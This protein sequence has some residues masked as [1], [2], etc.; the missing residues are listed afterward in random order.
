V[1][2]FNQDEQRLIRTAIEN[3]E[4]HS[5]GQLRVCIEKNCSGDAISRAAKYFYQLNMQKTRLRNGVLIYVATV[6]RKFAII[7]D[8][9]ITQLVSASFWDETKEAMLKH[10]KYGNIVDG[11]ITGIQIAG[12]YMQKYFPNESL[13]E[14]PDGR[15]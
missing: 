13:I 11:I 6:D 7:G 15:N 12:E 5:S 9:G 3:V 2:V 4:L 8:T 10:L 1:I 14:M